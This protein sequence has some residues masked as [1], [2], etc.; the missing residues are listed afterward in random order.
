MLQ[1]T[2]QGPW[3]VS[4]PLRLN[5]HPPFILDSFCFSVS[6]RLRKYS[7]VILFLGASAGC[8]VNGE[9]GEGTGQSNEAAIVDAGADT[10]EADVLTTEALGE[11]DEVSDP[12]SPAVT[13]ES[14]VTV[15]TD[16]LE[17]RL[18]PNRRSNSPQVE[19]TVRNVSQ[20]TLF[21]SEQHLLSAVETLH[22]EGAF[23]EA[24]SPWTGAQALP[25]GA[26]MVGTYPMVGDILV[27]VHG[28]ESVLQALAEAEGEYRIMPWVFFDRGLS[29]PVPDSL[30]RSTAFRLDM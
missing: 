7:A 15:N 18:T 8:S 28:E 9:G 19:Y 16:S 1:L 27:E 2:R 25:P 3:L 26:S 5:H 10:S 17:Y 20:D 14:L 29:R 11:T 13:L 30:I 24:A 6:K 23:L 12:A 4:C 22:K 21:A